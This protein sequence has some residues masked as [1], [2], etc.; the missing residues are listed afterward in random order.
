[1]LRALEREGPQTSTQLRDDL[2]TSDSQISRTGQQLLAHGLVSQRRVG[3]QALWELT[4]RGG[5]LVRRDGDC[6]RAA[7]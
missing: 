4:P 2:A 5:E 3:R 7:G 1:M 6:G